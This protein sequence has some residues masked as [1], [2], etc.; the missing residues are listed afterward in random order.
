MS[1]K[2][3]N[4]NNWESKALESRLVTVSAVDNQELT[5]VNIFTSRKNN[6]NSFPHIHTHSP[7]YT[8]IKKKY[9]HTRAHFSQGKPVS[10]LKMDVSILIQVIMQTMKNSIQ[11]SP[12]QTTFKEE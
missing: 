1:K 5:E 3:I 10:K 7:M 9:V 6:T 11:F 4:E 8:F 2:C 12:E